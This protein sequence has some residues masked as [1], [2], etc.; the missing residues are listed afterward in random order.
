MS[1]G[2]TENSSASPGGDETIVWNIYLYQIPYMVG[3]NAYTNEKH[4][5]YASTLQAIS[6][7]EGDCSTKVVVMC[8]CFVDMGAP[9]KTQVENGLS[10]L[11][12]FWVK[13]IDTSD[14]D[15]FTLNHSGLHDK[16]G[17]KINTSDPLTSAQRRSG[18]FLYFM[19]TV[20]P[21][22]AGPNCKHSR[23]NCRACVQLL[24]DVDEIYAIINTQMLKKPHGLLV[25][26]VAL[27]NGEKPD[28]GTLKKE[29]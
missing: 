27:D 25:H 24:I 28:I 8:A 9:V 29:K 7:G 4:N 3:T 5:F 23:M 14:Q 18:R 15:F 16:E 17:G 12:G 26:L 22:Q 19:M 6:V 10:K 1:Q 21:E 2:R 20:Q 11:F 13:T